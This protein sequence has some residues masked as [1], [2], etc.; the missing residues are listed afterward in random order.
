M[1]ALAAVCFA[2]F[3]SGLD[4]ALCVWHTSSRANPL[5]ATHK[6]MAVLKLLFN[7][8]W[9]PRRRA[10]LG[11]EA[12]ALYEESLGRSAFLNFRFLREAL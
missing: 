1:N 9:S 10:P 11:L 5:I 6:T 12:L 7:L 4:V 2:G 8:I 3:L